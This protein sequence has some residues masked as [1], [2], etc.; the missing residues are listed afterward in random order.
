MV[1][2]ESLRVPHAPFNVANDDGIARTPG[3]DLDLFEHLPTPTALLDR[4][5]V[6]VRANLAWRVD[7]SL[8]SSHRD[9]G[10]GLRYVVLL[11]DA[12]PPEA[13]ASLVTGLANP[14]PTRF[15]VPCGRG[16]VERWISV[17]RAPLADGHVMIEHRDVTEQH[18]SARRGSI[19]ARLA[20]E[21]PGAPS[22]ET[23]R[24]LCGVMGWSLA[25]M[26]RDAGSSDG[27]TLALVAGE[28]RR[29]K[30]AWGMLHESSGAACA[31]YRER[32][33]RCADAPSRTERGLLQECLRTKAIGIKRVIAVPCVGGALTFYSSTQRC[34]DAALLALLA[35]RFGGIAEP[36]RAER[37]AAREV[38]TEDRVTLAAMSPA[39]VLLW[40]EVS[41]GKRSLAREIHRRG[42][43]AHERLVS[44]PRGAGVPELVRAAEES[45]GGT[46]VIEE[47]GGLDAASQRWLCE[48]MT[49]G[50]FSATDPS[51]HRGF[52]ARVI[53]CALRA[54]EALRESGAVDEAL[55]DRVG[56][57]SVGLLPL[58]AR[59]GELAAL[60][61]AALR[62]IARSWGL[63][64][65]TLSEDAVLAITAMPWGG[66]FAELRAVLERA[67]LGVGSVVTASSIAA[68]RRS[69]APSVEAPVAALVEAEEPDARL[70]SSERAHVERVL[71]QTEF[72]MSAAARILGISR[73]K[74]YARVNAWR[75]DLEAM[76]S[77]A[78]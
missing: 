70:A 69:T 54:P 9:G 46:L 6:I 60:A 53:A 75:I 35:L 72:K 73:S 37:S 63:A 32:A 22:A 38:S 65:P 68:A 49:E 13:R 18:Q 20:G 25:A 17:E 43:R 7:P 62:D 39:P 61:T 30:R 33:P 34:P 40:G 14:A 26:W 8:G 59:R 36:P 48:A 56:V 24:W 12:V 19:D 67:W 55:L 1:L 64:A 78:S 11:Q 77:S 41:T 52:S 2:P 31:A 10:L 5:G 44:V 50:R 71:R 45:T 29:G 76:R 28:V 74:L 21:P 47:L 27:L 3:P 23:L 66:N 4:A 57:I 42:G 16:D 15:T 51:S 58:R